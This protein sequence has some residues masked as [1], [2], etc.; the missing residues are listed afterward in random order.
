MKHLLLLICAAILCFS[1]YES[2]LFAD[3]SNEMSDS[4]VDAYYGSLKQQVDKQN[5]LVEDMLQSVKDRKTIFGQAQRAEMESAIVDL[6]VKR[7][8][9]ANFHGKE[10]VKKSPVIREK[11]LQVMSQR[12]ITEADLASL[13]SVVQ[14]EKKRYNIR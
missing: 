2:T 8:L 4:E 7:T 14:E 5:K 12:N 10:S 1:G 9:Y 3:T 13:Q 6:D 11:L